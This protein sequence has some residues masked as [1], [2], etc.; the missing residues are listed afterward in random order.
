VEESEE[1][2]CVLKP[3]ELKSAPARP[4]QLFHYDDIE[5][6][7]AL[8]VRLMMAVVWAH[9]FEQGNKRTGFAAAEIFLDANGYLLD[10]PDFE[11]IAELIIEAAADPSLEDDVV[12]LFRRN[13]IEMA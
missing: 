10:I 4:R 13:L 3:H 6:I 9:P 11:D 12:E 5:D 2:F 1:P 7:A 8:A